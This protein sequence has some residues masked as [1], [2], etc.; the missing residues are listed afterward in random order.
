MKLREFMTEIFL[1]METKNKVFVKT[2]F[3][4]D[5]TKRVVNIL[6]K[7]RKIKYRQKITHKTHF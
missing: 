6:K 2:C 4:Q 7:Y 1:L 5:K 3:K